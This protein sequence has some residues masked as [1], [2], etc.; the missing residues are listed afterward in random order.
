[1]ISSK[2]KL[3]LFAIIL[4]SLLYLAFPSGLSSGDGWYYAA[5]IK[6]YGEIFLPHHLL[7]NAL[8]IVFCWIPSHVGFEV[9]SSMKVMNALFA[10]LSLTAIQRILYYYKLTEMQVAMK[11][12]IAGLSFSVLRYATENETYI[13]PLYFAL[14]ASLNY[15]K[16]TDNG[17]V[18]NLLYAGLQA[19]VAVLFHQTYIFWWLGLLVGFILEKRKKHLLL[20]ILISVIGPVIYLIVILTTQGELRWDNIIGFLLGDFKNGARLEVTSRGIFFSVV[21]LIRSFIQVHGYMFNMVRENLLLLVPGIVSLFFFIYAFL[22]FPVKGT[23]N[24]SPRFA[25][26]HILILA[27]QFIFAVVSSGNAEFMVMIPVLIII[28]FPFYASGYERFL[29]RLLV[30]M[31]IWNISYG[32]IPLSYKSSAPEQFLCRVALSVNEPVIIASD[33]HLLKSMIYYQT[34]DTIIPN[35]YKSPAILQISGKDATYL[36][37]VIINALNKG[38]PVYTD[39]L[40]KKNLS[41]LSIIEGT[42][43][44]DFFRKYESILTKTWNRTTGTSSIYRIV[45]KH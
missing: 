24:V 32:L 37:G 29:F 8:G 1:M 19:S 7:Y 18:R 42:N 6:Y 45:S 36:D 41:R 12:C 34:G 43:N 15:L 25:N 14:I 28:L 5:S 35:I 30:G 9:I 26:I 10:F 40:D 13:V 39:C 31:A 17:E 33:D 44:S 16:Y 3:S 22:K 20:Y 2:H 4:L 11:I 21:N 27:L 23:V 38:I